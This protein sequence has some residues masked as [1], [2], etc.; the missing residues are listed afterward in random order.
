MAGYILQLLQPS[1]L[2][3][4]EVLES[5]KRDLYKS[6]VIVVMDEPLSINAYVSVPLI[7]MLDSLEWPISLSKK[8]CLTGLGWRLSPVCPSTETPSSFPNGIWKFY[9][10]F[11]L[12]FCCLCFEKGWRLVFC[13]NCLSSVSPIQIS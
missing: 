7:V 13:L 11:S 9:Y 4:A 5:R 12:P 2:L 3:E 6:S 8:L 10:P 1:N